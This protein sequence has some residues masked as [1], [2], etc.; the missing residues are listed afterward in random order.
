[1]Q[2]NITY[3]PSLSHKTSR[4]WEYLI[5]LFSIGCILALLAP[6][7]SKASELKSP[8]N[9]RV[10]SQDK[11]PPGKKQPA[12]FILQVENNAAQMAKSML[13]AGSQG[14]IV[15]IPNQ[16]RYQLGQKVRMVAIPNPG[17]AFQGW[18]GS[19]S[20]KTNP[21][22]ITL[23][24]NTHI[25]ANFEPRKEENTLHVDGKAD[26]PGDGSVS[27]PFPS[28]Q[29]A[30]YAAQPGQTIL[31]QDGTYR[32][33]LFTRRGGNAQEG[34]IT[35]LAQNKG[36]VKITKKERLL[37]VSHP[38]I[39]ISGLEFD[40]QFSTTNGAI[41]VKQ[42]AENLLLQD[43][44]LK[45]NARHGINISY[46]PQ[47]SILD[48]LIHSC[49]W[50]ED[51]D[52]EDTQFKRID[53]HGLVATGVEG[54]MV[55]G[56]EIRDV[57]GDAFQLEYGSWDEVLLDGVTFWNR[58][59]PEETAQALGFPDLA[60]L[61]PGEDAVDTKA[62]ADEVRGRLRIQNSEFYGWNGD[63][64]AN[65]AALNLKHKVSAQVQ[66]CTFYHNY[67]A[68]R[69]R[70]PVGGFPGAYVKVDNNTFRDN[71]IHIRAED[72]IEELKIFNNIF[73]AHD[74]KALQQ[75]P[76]RRG[77]GSGFEAEDN[78]VMGAENPFE[79]LQQ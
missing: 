26:P 20:G 43:I 72:R 73:Y 62:T 77:I 37:T 60:G 18:Q 50:F 76:S 34:P 30:L 52:Q 44:T 23:Q 49:L 64:I 33:A 12:L 58:P 74:S 78:Q 38:H 51:A 57:S 17:Y 68:L 35:L 41:R 75:A 7:T 36:Q 2:S 21:Q 19:L 29:A 48:S 42:G 10:A 15:A 8:R 9:L 22:M 1:M 47:V 40:A 39:I 69:L 16:E 54:L 61:N 55:A 11:P 66:G 27:R 6:E 70:G 59:L 63:F 28:I 3:C 53:A 4:C 13:K 31:V 5:I 24:R 46:A 45:N 71:K 79:A 32:E 25:K 67:I 56:T 14:K 65:A